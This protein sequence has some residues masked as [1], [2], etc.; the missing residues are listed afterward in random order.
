ME[1]LEN[2]IKENLKLMRSQEKG[3]MKYL[4]MEESIGG[5]AGHNRAA[6]NF[7]F[8]QKTGKIVYFGNIQ[9]V[10]KE[11]K[12]KYPNGAFVVEIFPKDFS[13]KIVELFIWNYLGFKINNAAVEILKATMDAYNKEFGK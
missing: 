11:I 10:P 1:K 5:N 12:N 8:C 6:L 13:H 7:Y 4:L 9:N 2:I 3:G